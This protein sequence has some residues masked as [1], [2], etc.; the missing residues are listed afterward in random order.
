MAPTRQGE[1][2]RQWRRWPWRSAPAGWSDPA[3]VWGM[4]IFCKARTKLDGRGCC[5]SVITKSRRPAFSSTQKC[6][7]HAHPPKLQ[8]RCKIGSVYPTP[9]SRLHPANILCAYFIGHILGLGRVI[10][11]CAP[12]K[13]F[14]KRRHPQLGLRVAPMFNRKEFSSPSQHSATESLFNDIGSNF[15]CHTAPS[16]HLQSKS[17][18]FPYFTIGPFP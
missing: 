13:A 7:T 15:F 16:R 8:S 11:N 14:T 12:V 4:I 3:R 18:T 6:G 17:L 1:G 5:L 10:L 2:S 9:C